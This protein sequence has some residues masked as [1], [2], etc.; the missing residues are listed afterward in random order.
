MFVYLGQC[1]KIILLRQ[2]RPQKLARNLCITSV[3][4]SQNHWRINFREHGKYKH[5]LVHNPSN[6]ADLLIQPIRN[7]SRNTLY[8]D[9]GHKYR[10]FFNRRRAI[11]ISATVTVLLV[12]LYL[13]DKGCVYILNFS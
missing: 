7:V 1:G 11:V 2:N 10:K 4:A 5:L 8:T 6:K 13:E 3:T 12:V 9:Y